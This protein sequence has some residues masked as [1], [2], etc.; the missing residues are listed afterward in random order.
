MFSECGWRH[1]CE[2][3]KYFSEVIFRMEAH[4]IADLRYRLVAVAQVVAGEGH[5]Q[6]ID[7]VVKADLQLVRK[8][9]RNIVAADMQL[10]FQER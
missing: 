3:E 4:Q 6:G 1:A 5:P 2:I 8:Q 7:I 9:M 10:V